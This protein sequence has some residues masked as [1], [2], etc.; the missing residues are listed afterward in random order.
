MVAATQSAA[1]LRQEADEV[2]CLHE[3]DEFFAVDAWYRVFDQV[4]DAEVLDLLEKA[5]A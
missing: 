1:A 3:L 2:V 4:S 5:R